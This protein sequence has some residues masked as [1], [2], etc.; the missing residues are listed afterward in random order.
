MT[1]QNVSLDCLLWSC[2]FFYIVRYNKQ[3]V[4]IICWVDLFYYVLYGWRYHRSIFQCLLPKED[5]VSLMT[6]QS[7][8]H[9]PYFI[10]VL[11]FSRTWCNSRG[12]RLKKR[13]KSFIIYIFGLLHIIKAHYID[14]RWLPSVAVKVS[15]DNI[16]Y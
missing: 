1:V 2:I 15:G 3:I 4:N 12:A 13:L 14:A 10:L 6:K 8:G 9:G 16:Y 5:S 11:F 7:I